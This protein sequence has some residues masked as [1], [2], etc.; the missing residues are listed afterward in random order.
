MKRALLLAVLFASPVHAQV[1][2]H[3]PVA[4]TMAQLTSPDAR[5]RRAA[6]ERLAFEGTHDLLADP[7]RIAIEH[8]AVPEPLTAMIATLARRADARDLET[9][10]A[11]WER[12]GASDRMWLLG[13][14][15][16]IG[17]DGA[18]AAMRHHLASEGT[19]ARACQALVRTPERV[20]WLAGTLEDASV[21]D[22]VVS[23]LA[24][25]EPSE[26]RDAALV[27]AGLDLEPTSAR[28]V[29]AALVH[30]TSAEEAAAALAGT[31]LARADGM[32]EVA[33]LA[34]LARHAPDRLSIDAWRTHLVHGDD[35]E[36]SALRALLVLAPSIADEALSAARARDAASA[37]RALG[38]LIDRN[39][40]GD[41]HRVAQFVA[42]DATRAAALDHLASSV[43]G[44][45]QLSS[46]PPASDVDLALALARPDGS[47]RVALLARTQSIV[48]RAWVGDADAAACM[49]RGGIAGAA[50]LALVR[51]GADGA[52][53]LTSERDPAVVAWLAIAA[54]NEAIDP[55]ALEALLDEDDTRAP[56]V[57][58]AVHTMLA[59]S[60]SRRRAIET[61]LVEATRDDDEH[62]RAE[63]VRALGAWGRPVHRAVVLRALEDSSA[64][65][66]LAAAYAL[67]GVGVE[68]RAHVRVIGRARVEEDPR[69]LA[70]LRGATVVPAQAPLQVRVVEHDPSLAGMARVTLLLADGRAL[71]LAP[72][73]GVVIVPDVPD[74]PAIV[75][76]AT[77]SPPSRH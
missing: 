69:V 22:R 36:A 3:A 25:A 48:V 59:S 61:R 49:A 29:L 40:A 64:Q 52:R 26:V 11:A 77:A 67:P 8:E 60:P 58:L 51:A 73:D 7:L 16:E 65:V 47:E 54:R 76:L 23:C 2:S 30:T 72:V 75:R 20:R 63:A 33:A 24:R 38:A 19:S 71:R 9:I 5:V 13:A 15:D 21:R 39:D 53:A 45:L 17:T 62:V 70:A 31:A 35:R 4:R 66:R 57:S 14:E 10:E 1:L 46:L 56:A 37:E 28:D 68:P 42:L 27:Q 18:L 43:G 34:I 32:L 44:A 6:A 55:T 41:L 74:S 50:C 12:V